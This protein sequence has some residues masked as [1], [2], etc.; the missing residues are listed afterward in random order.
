MVKECPVTILL[1]KPQNSNDR[2]KIACRNKKKNTRFNNQENRYKPVE[3]L[4][5]TEQ[6]LAAGSQLELMFFAYW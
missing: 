1:P 4:S 2:A 5:V 6:K 3:S